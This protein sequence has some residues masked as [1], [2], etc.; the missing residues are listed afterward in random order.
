MRLNTGAR[1]FA[2][3]LIFLSNPVFASS[4]SHRASHDTFDDSA[5]ILIQGEVTAN[6]KVLSGAKVQIVVNGGRGVRRVIDETITNDFGAFQVENKSRLPRR[7]IK[8]IVAHSG[9]IR[10]VSQW[11][12]QST[13]TVGRQLIELK[14]GTAVDGFVF[15]AKG[16]PANNVSIQVRNPDF[17]TRQ[18]H[19]WLENLV[20][21]PDSVKSDE[22]GYFRFEEHLSGVLNLSA[23]AVDKASS[24]QKVEL[25]AGVTNTQLTIHL[26]DGASV[27]GKVY[28]DGSAA[29]N[30]ALLW[31]CDHGSSYWSPQLS[32]DDGSFILKNIVGEGNCGVVA[33]PAD[34]DSSSLLILSKNIKTARKGFIRTRLKARAGDKGLMLFIKSEQPGSALIGFD[35]KY[36]SYHGDFQIIPLGDQADT[37]TTLKKS[38]YAPKETFILDN[39]RPGRYRLVS[40]VDDGKG[41]KPVIFHIEPSKQTKVT[42]QI[43]PGFIRGSAIGRVL[44]VVTKEPIPFATM[45]HSQR[46]VATIGISI[47]SNGVFSRDFVGEELDITISAVGYKDKHIKME[48]T[49]GISTDFGDIYLDRKK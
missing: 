37:T 44:D 19:A 33:H 24:K 29:G 30:I 43:E 36:S 14:K 15:D 46:N 40:E 17:D 16:N 8:L 48:L 3:I 7:P 28:M 42:V 9:Y 49:E 45:S 22:N 27:S 41:A 26:D 38:L 25:L 34:S 39:M 35:G 6:G 5:P 23:R 4:V 18:L 1:L 12:E 13:P 32:G 47:G 10:H 31:E 11:I 20:A 2:L 21:M